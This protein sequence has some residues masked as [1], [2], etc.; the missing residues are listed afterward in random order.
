M[1]GRGTDQFL[2]GNC[3]KEAPHLDITFLASRLEEYTSVVSSTPNCFTVAH[4]THGFAFGDFSY[5]QPNAIQKYQVK[6]PR[7]IQFIGFKHHEILMMDLFYEGFLCGL[8]TVS[9][10]SG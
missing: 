9:S 4:L 1:L 5:L 2:L 8:A 3:N 7:N 10:P 6:Y